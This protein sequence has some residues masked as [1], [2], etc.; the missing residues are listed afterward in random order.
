MSATACVV[1]RDT[2]PTGEKEGDISLMT[3]ES[4]NLVGITWYLATLNGNKVSKGQ[5]GKPLSLLFNDEKNKA[6]GFAG[7]NQFFSI[8]SIEQEKLTLGALAMTRK[9]C[10]KYSLL[11]RQFT[12]ALNETRYFDIKENQLHLSDQQQNVIAIFIQG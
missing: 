1:Q 6:S 8:F 2:E 11:E 4:G 5:G 10:T 3:R 7:C 12:K 9:H